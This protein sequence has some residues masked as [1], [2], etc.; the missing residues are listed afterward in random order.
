MRTI[1][2]LSIDSRVMM[3]SN[4]GNGVSGYLFLNTGEHRMF[5]FTLNLVYVRQVVFEHVCF[6]IGMSTDEKEPSL[7]EVAEVKDIFWQKD[8]EVHFVYPRWADIKEAAGFC[9]EQPDSSWSLWRPREGWN[10]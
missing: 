8:E 6:Q 5:S 2:D 3:Q 10:Y 7:A 9:K 1:G 4:T